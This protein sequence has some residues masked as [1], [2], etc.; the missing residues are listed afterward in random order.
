M[1]RLSKDNRR[2]KGN[3]RLIQGEQS[4][5]ADCQ[6]HCCVDWSGT[7]VERILGDS[8]M[9]S[10]VALVPIVETRAES[11]KMFIESS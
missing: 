5:P 6:L 11:E 4:H 3:L 2:S 1:P 7:R 8:E 9:D 10:W